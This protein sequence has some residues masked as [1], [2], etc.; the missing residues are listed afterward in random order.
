MWE[1]GEEI[2]VR[3][4][5]PVAEL[6]SKCVLARCDYEG[7]LSVYNIFKFYNSHT[8]FTLEGL[9]VY[10][11]PNLGPGSIIRRPEQQGYKCF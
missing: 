10:A 5:L 2:R 6:I 11:W 9:T 4:E 3:V 7:F 8:Q 1:G